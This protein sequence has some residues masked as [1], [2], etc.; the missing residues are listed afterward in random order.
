MPC[1]LFFW[2]IPSL[3]CSPFLSNSFKAH[4]RCIFW[5]LCVKMSLFSLHTWLIVWLVIKFWVDN[6]FPSKLKLLLHR[7]WP[8]VLQM[9]SLMSG[10]FSGNWLLFSFHF[11]TPTPHMKGSRNLPLS[12]VFWNITMIYLGFLKK[13]SPAQP[14]VGPFDLETSALRIFS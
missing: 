5:I 9:G 4:G 13:I 11:P 3:R 12:L 2:F 10:W 8:L 6:N 7:L 1:F 14:S